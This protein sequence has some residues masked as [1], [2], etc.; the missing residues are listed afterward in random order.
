M[1]TDNNIYDPLHT[2]LAL[3]TAIVSI[4]RVINTKDRIILNQEY[5][6]IINRLAVG[7]IEAD[8]E[9]T[10][11][12]AGLMKF[13]T[14]QNL[15]NDTNQRLKENVDKQKK[16]LLKQALSKINA[17]GGD[18]FWEW[19]GSFAISCMSSYFSYQTTKAELD[20]GIEYNE[21]QLKQK[22]IEECNDLQL[23]LLNSSWNLLR[24]NTKL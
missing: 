21:W 4:H 19:F 13:I 9:I 18:N 3:N 6:T 17:R 1:E 12:F 5:E 7:N 23:K 15:R 11:L 22:D 16:R 10:S 2:M 8:D 20:E 14:G 24:R